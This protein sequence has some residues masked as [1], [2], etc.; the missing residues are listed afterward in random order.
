[1]PYITDCL[2]VPPNVDSVLPGNPYSFS[3]VVPPAGTLIA[4]I[5]FPVLG[6][7]VQWVLSDKTSGSPLVEGQH[8]RILSGGLSELSLSVVFIAGAAPRTVSVIPKLTLVELGGNKEASN[9]TAVDIPIP[10]GPAGDPPLL[11][12]CLWTWPDLSAVAAGQPLDFAVQVP[13]TGTPSLLGPFPPVSSVVQW[14]LMDTSPTPQPLQQGIDYQI[15]AGGLAAPSLSV[16]F[17]PQKIDRTVTIMPVLKLFG[18]G[19]STPQISNFAKQ[20]ITLKA[21]QPAE[22]QRLTSLLQ[23]SLAVVTDKV[24][25]EPGELVTLKLIPRDVLDVPK[26]VTS[27]LEEL[28]QVEIRGAIPLDNIIKAFLSP[29]TGVFGQLVPQSKSAANEAA[30]N[31]SSLLGKLFSIPLA[32]DINGSRVSK[33]LAPINPPMVPSLSVLDGAQ[34]LSGSVPIGSWTQSVKLSN[35][36]WSVSD[37]SPTPPTYSDVSPGLILQKSLLLRPAIVPLTLE[38]SQALLPTPLTVTAIVT[39]NCPPLDDVVITL[40]IPLQR[41]PL[42]L[43]HIAAVFRHCFDDTTN[44]GDQ[45]V[46]LTTSFKSA[47][48][49]SSRADCLDMINRLTGIL[50]KIVTLAKN[51]QVDW[52]DFLQL[53]KT[54]SVLA[55]V[56]SRIALDQREDKLLF[57]PCLPKP[58]GSTAVDLTNVPNWN[59]VISAVI[60]IGPLASAS[61]QRF[62][63]SDAD[64]NASITFG[65]ALGSIIPCLDEDSF[66]QCQQIPPGSAIGNPPSGQK[67]NDILE[68]L[69]FIN[70]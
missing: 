54:L 69:D 3:V 53:S 28:P 32:I 30:L 59:N 62:V 22:T 9:F 6:S 44:A 50:N 52:N 45:R 14:L 7:A 43:P 5:S 29:V 8:Y 17:Q 65:T 63:V 42:P 70:G 39:L 1:M 13:P 18:A 2:F 46:V 16:A 15:L 27:I 51:L 64:G 25:I 31:V 35:V 36:T 47:P 20:T 57:I 40:S 48:F 41:L 55:D 34:D 12:S 60:A 23:K 66:D 11:P 10:A 24:V 26:V 61:A 33:T 68:K 21:I 4:G 37:G 19:L 49:L 67:M 56:L 58:D 38:S